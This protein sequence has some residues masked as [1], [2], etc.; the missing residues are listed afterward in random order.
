MI[1]YRNK[2][3]F[4]KPAC[5]II[6]LLFGFVSDSTKMKTILRQQCCLF[7]I[8]VRKHHVKANHR[9]S[10]CTK[11]VK[12]SLKHLFKRLQVD[13]LQYFIFRRLSLRMTHPSQCFRHFYPTQKMGLSTWWGE[14][15]KIRSKNCRGQFHSWYDSCDCITKCT[16]HLFIIAI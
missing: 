9:V 15:W 16:M 10:Y 5:L 7:D 3:L 2:E 4:E 13:T 6:R 14:A 1:S 8:W 12:P 11:S